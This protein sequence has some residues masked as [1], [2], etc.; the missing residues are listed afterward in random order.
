MAGDSIEFLS[1]VLLVSRNPVRLAEF[2]RNV[3][4]IP[5]E[6]E[7]HGEPEP[8]DPRGS[9]SG[10]GP[11]FGCTLGDL[12]FAIHPI[13]EFPDGRSG[14]GSVK[15]AFT[16]FDLEAVVARVKEFSIDLLYP[17]NDTG[18]FRI[19]AFCDPDG[20]LI[21]LTELCDAWYEHLERRKA[22]GHDLLT[23]WR[24]HGRD[25]NEAHEDA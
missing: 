2:Y 15:L 20:N 3:L 17:P 8:G 21:E 25:G 10:A 23:R 4:G 19:T 9:R 7:H 5:L 6:P 16:V 1:A 24:E 11:H 22:R 12:R 14:V 18:F 13:D